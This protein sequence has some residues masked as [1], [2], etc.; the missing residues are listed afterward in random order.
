MFKLVEDR[1]KKGEQLSTTFCLTVSELMN[2]DDKIV[3]IDSDLA[4]PSGSALI[5][6]AHPDRFINVGIAEANMV[7]VAS[8]LSIEGFKPFVHSFAPFAS[9]RVFDQI[10]L[11]GAYAKT[12][13][14]VYGSDPGFTVGPN[15][16]THTSFEDVALYRTIPDAVI[17]DPADVTQLKCAV[18]QAA[19]EEGIKYIRINRKAVR[20]VY[21]P[22]SKFVFGK[23]NVVKKG[24]DVL[25][26]T[27]GQILSDALDAAE[28]L[29]AKGVSVEVVDIYTIKPLDVELI[30]SEVKGKKAVVTFENHSIIG[31]LGSAVAEV[32]AENNVNVVFKRHGVTDR[33][34]QVG[35]AEFL[36]EEYNLT[37][38]DLVNTIES[39]L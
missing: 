1:N 10:Y 4:S 7:G 14:N 28:E 31:G 27:A 24:T 36:Q 37:S 3:F 22:G 35:T 26:I 38:K 18:K 32:L 39:L 29:E 5:E 21:E 34:G 11:S 23:G 9:R 19:S 8:G 2:D 15:G 6:K 25:V 16:G 12:T 17:V 33:F 20:N 30:L 13:I